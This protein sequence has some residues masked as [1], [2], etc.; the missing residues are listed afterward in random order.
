[1][2][3][4]AELDRSKVHPFVRATAEWVW[5]LLLIVFAV[6][7]LG[8]LFL[9]FDEVFVPVALAILVSAFLVPGVDWLD[10]KGLPRSLAVVIM[11]LVALGVVATVLTFVGRAFVHG[12]PALTAE[13]TV[14]IDRT[15]EWLV[16]GP[17]DVDEAQVRNLGSNIINLMEHNRP[18]WQAVPLRPR[19]RRP[20][21]SP[22]R[23]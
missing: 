15:R 11:L 8:R 21:W 9:E 2:R 17:L 22:V 5:R 14:T 20:N 18:S 1:M 10:R 7:V 23:Y 13:I 4:L 3:S 19:R 16:D 12:F 6:Y